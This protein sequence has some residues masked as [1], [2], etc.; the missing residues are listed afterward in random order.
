[1]VSVTKTPERREEWVTDP[2][3]QRLRYEGQQLPLIAHRGGKRRGG[4]RPRSAVTTVPVATRLTKAEFAEV[5]RRCEAN[6]MTVAEFVGYAVRRE[7]FAHQ[8]QGTR[9]RLRREQ[10]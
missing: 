7:L 10:K 4:G 3:T 1:M 6:G 8:G 9:A 2:E 5:E